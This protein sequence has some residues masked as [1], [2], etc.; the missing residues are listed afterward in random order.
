VTYGST[1]FAI[2]E[3]IK[4]KTTP[5]GKQ[6]GFALLVSA[7]ATS[8]FV[9]GMVGNPADISNVR[10]QND[11]SLPKQDRKNYGHVFDAL[12]RIGKEEG[13]S[14]YFRGL[15]PNCFRAAG[16]TACQLASYDGFKN[17][18]TG[19]LGLQDAPPAQLAASLLA[20]LVATTVCSPLDV[21]KTKAMS[22]PG[23]FSMMQLAVE[24]SKREGFRWVL[25]GWLPSFVRLG[26]HT[27]ATLLFLEQQKA[28]YRALKER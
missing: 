2:Y 13:P 8:G 26:P 4:E 25:R 27:I 16:M 14:G 10:M 24:M 18:L 7:A 20:S 3:T 9:G 15:W 5:S 11:A 12:A 6:P 22:E 17:L 1:R 21:I 23:R 28:L 19:R